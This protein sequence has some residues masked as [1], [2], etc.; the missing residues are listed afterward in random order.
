VFGLVF[1][2]IL[3]STNRAKYDLIGRTVLEEAHE[4]VDA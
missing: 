3:R 1:A 2:L 4:R